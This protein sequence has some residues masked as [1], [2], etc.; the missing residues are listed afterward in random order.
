[1]TQRNTHVHDNPLVHSTSIADGILEVGTSPTTKAEIFLLRLPEFKEYREGRLEGHGLDAACGRHGEAFFLSGGLSGL[2]MG[3]G[4]RNS[5]YKRRVPYD[6]E[7]GAPVSGLCRR[8][9]MES[10]ALGRATVGDG[11]VGWP[12]HERRGC[13]VFSA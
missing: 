8:C 1:M 6:E 10:A 9:L 12:C 13:V 7:T 2:A 4:W 5:L 3:R 11:C